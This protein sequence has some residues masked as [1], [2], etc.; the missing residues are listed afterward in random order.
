LAGAARS[1]DERY[2]QR[3]VNAANLAQQG[4]YAQARALIDAALKDPLFDTLEPQQRAAILAIGGVAAS[5][6]GDN[7]IARDLLERAVQLDGDDREYWTLLATAEQILGNRDRAS[8]YFA[9]VLRRWPDRAAQLDELV[10]KDLVH[11]SDKASEARL[12]LMRALF[13]AGW[14]RNLRGASGTW[15]ELALAMLARHETDAARSVVKRVEDPMVVLDLRSDRRFD[16]ISDAVASM[17]TVEAAAAA[18]VDRFR[19]R[20][21]QHPERVDLAVDLGSALLIAGRNEEALV[22]TD[23]ALAAVATAD[24]ASLE[25]ADERIWLM[26][27]RAIALRRLGR[28]DDAVAQMEAA[29]QVDEM[30]STNVSQTLNLGMFYCHLGR[31]KDAERAI[32]TLGP[33]SPY[34]QMVQVSVQHCIATQESDTAGAQ[35]AVEYAYDHRDDAPAVLLDI[36]LREN[37]VEHAA[38]ELIRQLGSTDSRD[39]ALDFVQ[40]FREP[41]PLPAMERSHA[42]REAVLQRQ[43]V[44]N[45]V[46]A[47]GRMGRF[48]VYAYGGME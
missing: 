23:A 11:R 22:Q 18:D 27:N 43:D 15:R 4:D 35:R 47:V 13:D 9:Q 26:D 7:R 5:S 41:A 24:P 34:G 40:H 20:T 8:N 2:R 44:R 46:D 16:A 25:A 3:I 29:R 42:A 31:P 30:G 19:A 6:T 28:F 38:V 33:V 14:D 45:A 48:D 1:A 36:L 39:D 37:D 12:A 17:P 10:I 21:K 32:G